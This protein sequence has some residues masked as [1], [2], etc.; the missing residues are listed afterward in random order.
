[1]STR[2]RAKHWTA[3][4]WDEC[5]SHMEGKD[6]HY[7][8]PGPRLIPAASPLYSSSC[9]ITRYH[10]KRRFEDR[11][12][13]PPTLT[14]E[15]GHP[16]FHTIINRSDGPAS[17]HIA[18]DEDL[19]VP[20]APVDYD[21]PFPD[22]PSRALNIRAFQPSEHLKGK[23]YNSLRKATTTDPPFDLVSK[24]PNHPSWI[25]IDGLLLKREENDSRDCPDVLYEAAHEG[26]NIRTEILCITH[27]LMAHMGAQKCF[28]YTS[29]HFD[30]MTMRT[31]FKDCI[32]RCHLCQMNKEPTAL[33]DG[34][35]T[36]LLVP[37][38]PFS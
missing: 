34:I 13:I 31:D 16:V 7:Y 4:V 12:A 11:W 6:R 2:H 21:D 5:E 8:P 26:D 30:W 24:I 9:F 38:E 18:P 15:D 32:R 17:N 25:L 10:P 3:C 14:G 35:V 28:K 23:W 29:R 1:M 27:E 19:P 36:P 20:D 33:S 22:Q 37:R